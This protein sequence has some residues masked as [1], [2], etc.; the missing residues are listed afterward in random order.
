M[1]FDNTKFVKGVTVEEAQSLN[2]KEIEIVPG[3]TAGTKTTIQGSQTSD[4]TVTMPDFT[5]T[6]VG[7]DSAQSLSNKTINADVNTITNIDDNEI[8]ANAGINAT[9]IG[10]GTVSNTEFS[11]LDGVTSPIQTQINSIAGG[12]GTVTNIGAG[13]GIFAQKVVSEFQ[14]KS[15]VASGDVSITSDADEVTIGVSV[16][17]SANPVLSNLAGP[18]AINEDLIFDKINPIISTK[19]NNNESLTLSTGDN[20]VG[21]SGN[22]N[23]STGPSVSNRGAVNIDGLFVNITTD[24]DFIDIN[25]AKIANATNPTDSQDVS[26]KFYADNYLGGIL[27][28]QSNPDTNDVITRSGSTYILKPATGIIVKRST[29]TLTGVAGSN[30]IAVPQQVINNTG[31]TQTNNF[32]TIPETGVYE[33]SYSMLMSKSS[34]FRVESFVSTTG[35][36]V[37]YAAFDYQNSVA[38]ASSTNHYAVCKGFEIRNFVAGD[39]I[40]LNLNV[41]TGSVDLFANDSRLNIKRIG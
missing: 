27:F 9:K 37:A 23:I 15:L 3:G 41:I 5:T 33:V 20:F 22:I 21:N 36:S 31:S 35:S 24:V 2:P 8:K 16:P 11:Y 17:A 25:G 28:S 4:V 7:T 40:S 38:N 39:T 34:T 10:T 30:V 1:A 12:T 32:I 18:T 6:L 14:F 29:A 19:S 13:E 26:T